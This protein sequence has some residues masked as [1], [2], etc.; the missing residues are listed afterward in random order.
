M[1]E[2]MNPV[3]ECLAVSKEYVDSDTSVK[4]LN[5]VALQLKRG[6]QLAIMGRS[7]SG[8]TTLLQLL[9]GLDT[10]TQGQVFLNGRD[11]QSLSERELEKMRNQCIGF[12]YQFHHL[13]PEFSALENVA[14]PQLIGNVLPELAKTRAK[15]LLDSVGLSTRYHHKPSELSGGE[16]QRVAIARALINEPDCLLADEPTG[17]LDDENAAHVLDV[18][19][20]LN[21]ERQTSIIIVTHDIALAARMDRTLHLHGGHFIESQ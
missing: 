6:E 4:V 16:R 17:N 11:L 7:G 19:Q 8:K 20:S 21:R 10:P 9:G 12:I 18:L 13:L 14:M 15:A 5:K 1:S 3:L 2:M